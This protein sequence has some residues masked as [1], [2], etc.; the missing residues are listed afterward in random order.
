MAAQPARRS[1]NHLE[2]DRDP[3][4]RAPHLWN[5]RNKGGYFIPFK[6]L[7]EDVCSMGE[8]NPVRE[9]FLRADGLRAR[10][11]ARG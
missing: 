2:S 5:I 6:L 3:L 11:P 7:L 8:R 10:I 4:R 9:L 1:T